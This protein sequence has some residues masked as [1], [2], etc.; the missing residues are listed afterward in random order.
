MQSY[1]A[2]AFRKADSRV[3]SLENCNVAQVYNGVGCHTIYFSGTLR[4]AFN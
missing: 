4:I 2:P 1:Q 3:S